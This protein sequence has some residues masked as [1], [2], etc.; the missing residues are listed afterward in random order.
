VSENLADVLAAVGDRWALLIVREVALGLRRFDEVQA[1]TRAPRTVL[2][3]RLRRL[4]AAG[5][6][7]T[8]PYQVPGRRAREEYTLT[9]AGLGLLPVLAALS[10][11]GEQHLGAG[12]VPE[13]VYRHCGCGGR[14]TAALRCECGEH[15]SAHFFGQCGRVVAEV[16]R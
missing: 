3:D 7:A 15:I 4:T 1:A 10:D 16:N 5:V 14:V 9:D 8:R 6:L 12:A 13:I 2:S 11:W